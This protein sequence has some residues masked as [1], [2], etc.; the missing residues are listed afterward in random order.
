MARHAL[1]RGD[2]LSETLASVD[3]LASSPLACVGLRLREVL[4]SAD[5]SHR[6][7]LLTAGDLWRLANYVDTILHSLPRTFGQRFWF[8]AALIQAMIRDWSDRNLFSSVVVPRYYG[9][10]GH[11]SIPM[12]VVEPP[13]ANPIERRAHVIDLILMPGEDRLEDINLLDYALLAHELGHNLLFRQDQ[14]FIPK[15]SEGIQAILRS[16]RLGAVADRGRARANAQKAIDELLALWNPNP[17]HRN[18]AHELGADLIALW[19][20]GPAYLAVFEDLLE[21]PHLNPHEVAPVHPP[22]AVRVAALIDGARRL[23]FSDFLTEL[24]RLPESWQRSGWNEHKTNWFLFLADPRLIQT[25]VDAALAFCEKLNLRLC[26]TDHLNALQPS[27]RNVELQECGTDLLL[28]AWL[29]CSQSGRDT[30][31]AWEES[32]VASLA[33]SV[34]P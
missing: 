1:R 4:V 10:W 17:D 9:D 19:V 34:T 26:T 5:N 30:Y 32:V 29:S 23:G 24:E 33:A 22:Y 7:G 27:F 8:D 15:V 13:G 16:L 12:P 21:G 3:L 31:S 25:A 20:L 14:L 11:A 18:W 28:A 6:A 2:R